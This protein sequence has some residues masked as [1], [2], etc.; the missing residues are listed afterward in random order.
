V[1]THY[2]V[3]GVPT[4][5]DTE[6]IRRA[7]LAVAK[8]SHPD[9]RQQ[10]DPAR[11][12][13][14]ERR[15]RA[16]NTAWNVLRDADRREA[17]DLSLA[18]PARAEPAARAATAAPRPSGV[19]GARPAPPSG[20]VV[21]AEH[22]SA[23]RYVPLAVVLVVL[24]AVLVVTAYANAGDGTPSDTVVRAP[25]PQVGDCVLVAALSQGRVPVA[26][27]CGNEGAYKVASITDTPRPC[28]P[29][30]QALA[31]SDQKTTLCLTD[32]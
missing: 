13:E 19:V 10:D 21:A 31:L 24:L 14:G 25:V 11:R 26:S 32:P 23:W 30:S 27:P 1:P 17:Y 22:A 12:A 2:E 6:T 9:R 5:A 7:Y 16:A 20:F 8:A 18:G 29:G 28:P 4:D 3:L 15:I